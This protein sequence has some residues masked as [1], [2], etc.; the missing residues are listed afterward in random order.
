LKNLNAYTYQRFL[1]QGKK[2]FCEFQYGLKQGIPIALG[3][4]P[5]SFTF[6]LM[7]VNGGLPV[8][9]AILISMTNLT[10]AGQFAGTTL[11]IS[12]AS[13]LEIT[14]TTFVVN[15]RYMLMSL[16]LSQKITP[17]MS[18]IQRYIMAFGITDETFALA[19]MEKKEITFAYMM[20]LIS[21]PYWGWALGTIIGALTS[22]VLPPMLQNSMG[23]AL[24]AMFIALVVP[25]AKKSKAAL[26]VSAIAIGI[27]SFFAWVPYVDKASGGWSIIIATILASSI[28][29][30]LFPIGEDEVE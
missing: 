26:V 21:G 27:S 16:S 11:I 30:I 24:Y 18:A 3:Y 15:I 6:G 28:G 4:I 29:A 14:L 17:Y 5:V 23:I 2:S 13:L 22:S 20:G 9:T 7:A 12:G 1:V 19:S 25:A 8:W 10:S